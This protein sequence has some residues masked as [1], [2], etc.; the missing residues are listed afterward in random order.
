MP[1]CLRRC[2]IC[3]R[4]MV[5]CRDLSSTKQRGCLPAAL[6]DRGLAA[7]LEP[8]SSLDTCHAATIVISRSIACSARYIQTFSRTLST[9]SDLQ[10]VTWCGIPSSDL[11]TINGEISL[12]VIMVRCR[13]TQA[14]SYR[15]QLRFDTSFQPD[16]TIVVRMDDRIT[17]RSITTYYR[18]SILPA[19][20]SSLL[21]T[22]ASRWMAIVSTPLSI[23]TSSFDRF[24]S[25]GLLDDR[26]KPPKVRNNPDRRNLCA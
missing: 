6:T 20:N 12:S 8:T 18:P 3:I 26:H 17:R 21:K 25:W 16:I 15:W 13:L 23:C 4:A 19:Q 1:K 11:I 2:A 14:G 22:T 7:F 9:G 5:F 10:G 24:R